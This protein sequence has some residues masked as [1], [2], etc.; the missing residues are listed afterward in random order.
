[1]ISWGE[2]QNLTTEDGRQWTLDRLE[3]RLIREFRDWIKVR[4]GDPFA[5]VERFQ[6]KMS[7]EA[8]MPFFKEAKAIQDDLR[9]FTLASPLAQKHMATE[10]GIACLAKL[11]LKKHHPAATE[12]DAFLV[13]QAM[14]KR[15]A[16]VLE[17]AQGSPPNGE[18]PAGGDAQG[19][20]STGGDFTGGFSSGERV[21]G[22]GK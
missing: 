16:E 10:E 19:R 5:L 14:G 21:F 12:E 13:G 3:I 11:L 9:A 15:M 7:D 18:S 22:P 8:L 1:M 17:R 2:V 6:G 4:E 20:A